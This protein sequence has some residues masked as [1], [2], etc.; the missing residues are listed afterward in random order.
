MIVVGRFVV[1]LRLVEPAD[2]GDDIATDE[3]QDPGFNWEVY[4]VKWE[5]QVGTGGTR[6]PCQNLLSSGDGTS[7][8][9]RA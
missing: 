1:R 5:I 9:R 3:E 4:E 2:E 6:R 7:T 8:G